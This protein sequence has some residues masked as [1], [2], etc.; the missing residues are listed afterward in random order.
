MVLIHAPTS[1]LEIL[2]IPIPFTRDRI[3]TKELPEFAHLRAHV[4]R[5]I[6]R[7]EAA[8]D[9]EAASA[10]ERSDGT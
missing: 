4:Y 1:V 5:L 7:D 2:P 3:E 9:G 6:K 8:V 10:G